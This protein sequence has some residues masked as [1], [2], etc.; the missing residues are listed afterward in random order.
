MNRKAKSPEIKSVLAK[1]FAAGL[2]K[3]RAKHE[4]TQAQLATRAAC[5][6][7]Y[8]SMIE[9]YAR[10]PTLE[11]IERLCQAMGIEPVKLLKGQF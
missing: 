2:A 4:L 9:G 7:S 11:M 1:L 6:T 10:V 8:V 3:A 5:S